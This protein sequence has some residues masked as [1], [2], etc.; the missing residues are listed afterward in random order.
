MRD[1]APIF[2]NNA[3]EPA[4][5]AQ[6]RAMEPQ[7]RLA[8][9]DNNDEPAQWLLPEEHLSRTEILLTTYAPANLAQARALKL[10]QISSVGYE[11]LDGPKLVDQGIRVC[12][13]AGVFDVP[14]AEWNIAMMF[15]L[16]RDLRGMIRHQEHGIWDRHERFQREL[17]GLTVGFWGYG[18]LARATARL[19]KFMGMNVHVLVRSLPVRRRESTYCVA[20]HGDPEGNLPDRVFS[21]DQKAQFLKDLDFLI[22]AVPLTNSTRGMVG[23]E[24]L[25]LLPRRAFVLNP[26]RGPIIDEQALLSVLR[27]GQIAGAAVDAHYYYPMPADHPLWRFPNVVMTPHIS[28]SNHSPY[29]RPRLWEIFV[30]NVRRYM[31]GEHRTLLNELSEG[32]LRGD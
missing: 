17:Y 23:E 15:A 7:V 1:P 30:E 11:H 9:S 19:C 12:N 5:L 20:G 32:Q 27:K 21:T 22:I 16:V 8:L 25:R 26:C 6:L 14:I 31:S 28:G 2:I 29:F 10:M 24:D 18:G 4:G 13:A 3:I